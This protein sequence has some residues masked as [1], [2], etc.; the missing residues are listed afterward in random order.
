MKFTASLFL[1]IG[2]V[3]VTQAQ[4]DKAAAKFNGTWTVVERNGKKPDNRKWVLKDGKITDFRGEKS[5]DGKYKIDT[6]KKAIDLIGETAHVAGIY[7]LSAD[8]K[9]LTVCGSEVPDGKKPGDVRPKQIE[10]KK[11]QIVWVLEKAK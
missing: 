4:D 5:K 10:M 9:K 2:F 1:L 11:G 7:E 8:G 3:F 6:A